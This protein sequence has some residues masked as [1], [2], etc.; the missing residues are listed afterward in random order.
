MPIK[1]GRYRIGYRNTPQFNTVTSWN[2]NIF[3][4]TGQ[5]IPR[6]KASDSE[7]W[8]FY[9][10]LNKRLSKQSRGWWFETPLRPLWRHRLEVRPWMNDYIPMKDKASNGHC[11]HRDTYKQ[12]GTLEILNW[13]MSE[14]KWC[15]M[16][17]HVLRMARW[18]LVSR[19]E[20]IWVMI[21]KAERLYNSVCPNPVVP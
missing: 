1:S 18:Q 7:I 5:W 19:V 12:V 4:V 17:K 16:R 6:T 2:G 8:F 3:R 10:R 14:V 21:V 11:Q 20:S 9:Q 15:I 13:N